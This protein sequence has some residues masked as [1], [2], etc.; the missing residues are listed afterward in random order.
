V[1][2]STQ[3]SAQQSGPL[4]NM[5]YST[6]MLFRGAKPDAAGVQATRS[7]VTRI[8]VN[9]VRMG[10]IPDGD[11]SYIA[12]QIAQATGI[13]QAEAQKRVDDLIAQGKAAAEKAR[14]VADATRKATS[15]LAIFTALSLVIGAFV[16]CVAAAFGGSQRDEH[17]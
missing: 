9:G 6:D 16:S 1:A 12:T 3:Q 7:E 10:G 11:K 2:Q 17:A 15:M 14:Q 4:A 13:P 5:G 8:L